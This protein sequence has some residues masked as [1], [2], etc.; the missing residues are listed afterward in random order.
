M[1]KGEL[2]RLR[3]TCR[4]LSP[5]LQNRMS[6]E[7]LAGLFNPA[8]RPQPNPEASF[9]DVAKLKVYKDDDGNVG[10]PVEN[11]FSC[12][13]VAGRR[14]KNGKKPISTAKT[15][16]LPELITIRDSFL[17]FKGSP[18]W[19]VDK[20]R[21]VMENQGKSVAVCVVRPKFTA[22]EFDVET[23][24]DK[25]MISED[26]VRNLLTTAG[27]SVGLCDFRPAKRGPFGRF[28]IANWNAREIVAE[29]E[30]AA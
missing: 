13:V 7:V 10:I 23:H 27:S 5:M 24:F 12:L 18:E 22:W 17:T 14:V 6:D 29:E 8:N 20:R 4:S 25:K 3:V 15:T 1:A 16:L 26:T 21:G 19:V 2:R 9:E 11:L 28:S 30:Q